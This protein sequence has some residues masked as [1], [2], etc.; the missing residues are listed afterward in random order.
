MRQLALLDLHPKIAVRVESYLAVPY[1]VTGT[2]RVAL[3]QERLATR[4]AAAANLRVLDCPGEAEP[5]VETLWWHRQHE[6]DP[7][8][9]WLRRVITDTARKL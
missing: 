3:M 6:D 2:D 5:I 9:A 7:A 4:L 1:F 8:H